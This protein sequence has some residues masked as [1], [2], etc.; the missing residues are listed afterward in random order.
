[1]FISVPQV[2]TVYKQ[3]VVLASILQE[4]DQGRT[5]LFEKVEGGYKVTVV[6]QDNVAEDIVTDENLKTAEYPGPLF[7]RAIKK[8][9]MALAQLERWRTPSSSEV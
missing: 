6:D 2:K 9:N 3:N 7:S 4:A 5:V 1:M 8:C